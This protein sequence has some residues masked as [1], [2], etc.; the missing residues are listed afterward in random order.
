MYKANIHNNNTF[1]HVLLFR[2]LILGSQEHATFVRFIKGQCVLPDKY[3]Q[4]A[5]RVIRPF[6]GQMTR[7]IIKWPP[8]QK[9][10]LRFRHR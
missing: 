8:P 6:K 7:V 9:L 3:G 10:K 5:S 1:I 4:I 2:C